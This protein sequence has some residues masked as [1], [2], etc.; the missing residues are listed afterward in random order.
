MNSAGEC[1]APQ[2]DIG[3]PPTDVVVTTPPPVAATVANRQTAPAPAVSQV[4]GATGL[5][6]AANARMQG[7]KRCVVRPFR[8]VLRGQ[9]I[10]RVT[11]YVN[12]RKAQTMSGGRS[13]YSLLIDPRQYRTG[14]VRVS[15]KVE[16]VA[17]SGKRPQTLSMTVL[18]CAKGAVAPRFAG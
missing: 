9:G 18:R 15:A 16:F 17:A 8:Q 3:T 1:V 13:S 5:V 6:V 4:L 11:M 14:V 2:Q 12:G 10:K 7:P